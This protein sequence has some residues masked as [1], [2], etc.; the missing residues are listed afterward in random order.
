MPSRAVVVSVFAF[1]FI[2][3]CRTFTLLDLR[4]RR[5]IV[6]GVLEGG[7]LRGLFVSKGTIWSWKSGDD[8]EEVRELT[9]PEVP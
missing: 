3:G 6:L 9:S 5:D 8:R 2:S 1:L 7:L 4:H